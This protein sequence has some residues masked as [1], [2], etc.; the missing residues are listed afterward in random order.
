MRAGWIRPWVRRGMVFLA[1]IVVHSC[2]TQAPMNLDSVSDAAKR[3][4]DH[5]LRDAFMRDPPTCIVVLPVEA[6]K[7][8]ELATRD[9]ESSV[10]R[11]L[12]IRVDRVVAGAYRDRLSRHLALDLQRATDLAVFATQVNCHHALSVT[13]G[14]GGMSYAVIWAERRIGL[15]M[16]LTRIGDPNSLLWLSRDEGMRADGGVPLSPL[17]IAGAMFRAGRVAGDK[18]QGLSLLDDVLRRMMRSLPDVRGSGSLPAYAP[19]RIV[20]SRPRSPTH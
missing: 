17:G 2:V 10:E 12:A 8:S 14:G 19:S 6:P 11:F 18:E 1:T 9:V 13:L 5:G 7:A 20:A 15:V 16:R 4:P 3:A